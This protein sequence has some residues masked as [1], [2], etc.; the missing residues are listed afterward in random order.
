VKIRYHS[1]LSKVIPEFHMVL[2]IYFLPLSGEL[3]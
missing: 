2:K 1:I 3:I